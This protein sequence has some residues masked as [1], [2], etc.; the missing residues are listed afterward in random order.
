VYIALVACTADWT[1]CLGVND[2]IKKKK[3]SASLF[4]SYLS[5]PSHLL[6]D[7][8]M[9]NWT[10]LPGVKN[11]DDHNNNKQWE[12]PLLEQTGRCNEKWLRT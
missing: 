1:S 6:F 8:S 9:F 12:E 3:M 2:E 10:S 4:W 11:D 7:A 5:C